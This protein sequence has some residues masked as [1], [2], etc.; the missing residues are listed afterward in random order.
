M[1]YLCELP[2]SW[3]AA[4]ASRLYLTNQLRRSV[5]S[6]E[7]FTTLDYEW[8]VIQGH[9]PYRW[10]IWVCI[11]FQVFVYRRWHCPPTIEY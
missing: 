4:L 1:V 7:F 3:P 5:P 8:D 11:F 9:R 10:T 6:W 2:F